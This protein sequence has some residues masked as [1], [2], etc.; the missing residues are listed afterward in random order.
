V[1]QLTISALGVIRFA[2]FELDTAAGELRRNGLRIRLEGQPI[3]TLAMLLERPGEVV[4]REEL[5]H[6][7]WPAD[8]FVDFE[9]GINT[10]VKRLRHALDDSA[11]TPRFIETL[12]RRGY[13]FIYPL[14]QAPSEVQHAPPI[15]RP[16]RPPRRTLA[17]VVA[18]LV[19]ALIAAVAVQWSWLRHRAVGQPGRPSIT[20]LAVLPL[21]NLSGDPSRDYFADGVT[22]ELITDLSRVA[23]L[24][25]IAR[26]SV[27]Q[28]K[29]TTKTTADIGRDLDVDALVEGSVVREG[30]HVRIVVQLVD[31]RS[32]AHL[33]AERYERDMTSAIALQRDIAREITEEIRLEAAPVSAARSHAVDPVAYELYLKGRY[34]HAKWSTPENLRKAIEFYDQAIAR[35]PRF[36]AAHAARGLSYSYLSAALI[37]AAP[38]G[39]EV[40]TQAR[41]SAQRALELDPASAE[42]YETLGWTAQVHGWNWEAAE[43]DYRRSIALNP[44]YAPP[45][46]LLAQTLNVL[47]R[48]H[49][50]LRFAQRAHELDPLSAQVQ[51]SLGEH[52]LYAGDIDRALA[53]ARDGIALHPDFWPM[54]TLLGNLYLRQ[55]KYDAA[56][57]SLRRAVDISRRH[58]YALGALGSG[59]ARAGDRRRAREVLHELLL[60]ARA[61][62]VAPPILARLY[63]SLGDNRRALAWMDKACA[64]HSPEAPRVLLWGPALGTLASDPRFPAL[65][66]RMNVPAAAPI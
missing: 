13:R 6:R 10:A 29:H 8:T 21:Q 28:Y 23:G 42:G 58:S 35:D 11:E 1:A 56:T 36:A 64:E 53:T 49:E 15:V 31:A 63:A 65:L 57:A 32:G 48:H 50:A 47:G 41:A 44:G 66:K 19:L 12:P 22:E 59:Y 7:L 43:A 40:V 46:M 52:Y 30:D 18:V 60:R 62:Y 5:R 24:K 20:S 61:A 25:V 17:V 33:W 9:H 16:A 34:L 2:S 26:T 39:P 55:G 27:M 51:W 54:H 38:P 4:S 3:Q 14:H 37:E 45:Y